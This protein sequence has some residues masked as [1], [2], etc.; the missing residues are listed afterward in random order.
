MPTIVACEAHASPF[1][2]LPQRTRATRFSTRRDFGSDLRALKLDP[3]CDPANELFKI[4]AVGF[5]PVLVEVPLAR[6]EGRGWQLARLASAADL[7]ESY[8][9]ARIDAGVIDATWDW[10]SQIEQ[11]LTRL[12]TRSD[13]EEVTARKEKALALE[14]LARSRVAALDRTGGNGQD[15]DA[16]GS[17]LA[18]GGRLRGRAPSRARRARRAY[19]SAIASGRR[20]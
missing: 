12:R 20:R 15:D 9:N 6:G 14:I 16:Q 4:A 18:P 17:L 2:R 19:S 10:G 7:I 5:P 1:S 3:L 11:R 8:I 13:E